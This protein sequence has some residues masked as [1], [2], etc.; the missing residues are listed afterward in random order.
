MN[1]IIEK[2]D[3]EK[4]DWDY[5]Q[6]IRKKN[7]KICDYE[8]SILSCLL[9]KPSLMNELIVNEND[10]YKYRR[11]FKY[12]KTFYETFGCLDMV[13]MVNKIKKGDRHLLVEVYDKLIDFEP[14]TSCFKE[15]QKGLLE[16]NHENKE[17]ILKEK[18]TSEI[19]SSTLKLSHNEF[20][21]EEYFEEIKKKEGE[22]TECTL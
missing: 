11:I 18:I 17:K 9:Q 4:V 7:R 1:N 14:N 10:F 5:E 16:Y 21:L 2:L 12:F 13:L 20:T 8:E 19:L 6:P 3:I 22:F 15:Y